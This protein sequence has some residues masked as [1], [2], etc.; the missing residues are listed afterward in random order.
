MVIAGQHRRT[1]PTPTMELKQDINQR[2]NGVKYP[3]FG[4]SPR[5]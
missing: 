2:E 1:E 4:L 5:K 3:A